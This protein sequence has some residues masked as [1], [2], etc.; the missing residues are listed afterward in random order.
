MASADLD[1]RHADEGDQP[2]LYDCRH[3]PPDTLCLLEVVG[4]IE[5]PEH[6]QI[7]PNTALW[8][9]D[10][11]RH[12]DAPQSDAEAQAWRKSWGY[13]NSA[14]TTKHAELLTSQYRQF[15]HAAQKTLQRPLLSIDALYSGLTFGLMAIDVFT[16]T[17]ARLNEV[18]QISLSHE[19]LVRLKMRAPNPISKN[20]STPPIRYLLRMIPKGERK[21]QRHDYFIGTETKRLLARTAQMLAEHYRLEGDERLPTVPFY[22]LHRRAHRFGPAPY[23]FQLGYRHLSDQAII[24]CVRFLLHGMALRTTSGRIVT[25]RA[26]LLRHGFATHAVQVEKIP[27]DIVGAWLH[28]KSLPVTEY[29]SQ[30]TDSMIADAADLYLSRIA[31]SIDVEQAVTRSPATLRRLYDDALRKTGT[32][33]NVVGG[34][35]TSHGLCKVQ[36]A[37]VGCAAKVPDPAQRS[38]VEHRRAW[39]ESERVYN[40]EQGLLP[41]LSRLEHLIEAA[42]IELREMDLIEQYRA[43]EP[44]FEGMNDVANNPP[45][46]QEGPQTPSRPYG[47][48]RKKRGTNTAT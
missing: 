13:V 35:C 23:L 42:D 9:A 1:G 29:Y 32:L 46:A 5:L 39:A 12:I 4:I 33:A 38:Q 20:S 6:Q 45:V 27:V 28:Q 25:L 8:F 11:L 47:R 18:M 43:D 19:C 41:E 34:H 14:F 44:P 48:A 3:Q 15:V 22:P 30:P 37:C 2:G 36:F 24:S 26:H 10:I 31:R 40:R 7:D 21:N 17:G 16:T